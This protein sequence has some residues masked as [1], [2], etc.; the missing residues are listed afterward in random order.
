MLAQGKESEVIAWIIVSRSLWLSDL[1]LTLYAKVTVRCGCQS[2][3]KEWLCHNVQAAY[4][5]AGSDPKDVSKNQFGLGLI[6]CNS[7]CK[8]KQKVNDSELQLRRPK[9][10]E[11]RSW[12]SNRL[13]WFETCCCH[14]NAIF[15]VLKVKESDNDR[16]GPKRKKRR[17]RV[18]QV[19]QTSTLQ[20]CISLKEKTE[21]FE[22][23]R[24]SLANRNSSFSN[25][26]LF[27]TWNG[28]F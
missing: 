19:T 1:I 4:R 12:N 21:H 5:D 23:L 17:E 24:Y 27:P 22:L 10:V 18:Q 3:K 6:P 20:V 9:S 26:K 2:L 8:S 16:Q 13:L 14:S 7:D 28:V 25:R 15:C 11:V